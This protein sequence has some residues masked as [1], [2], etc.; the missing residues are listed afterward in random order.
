ML[1]KFESG[2]VTPFCTL[3]NVMEQVPI[4]AMDDSGLIGAADGWR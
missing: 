3:A 4:T 1:F 2:L